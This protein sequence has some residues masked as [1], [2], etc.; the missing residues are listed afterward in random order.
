MESILVRLKEDEKQTLSRFYLYDGLSE[1]FNCVVLELPDRGNKKSISRVNSGKYTCV[2]RYSEKY[3]WH[4]ILLNVEGREY[5]LIH[6]GNYYT[7]TRGCLIFGN[8]FTDINGDGYLD[9]T[10]S[11]KTMKRLLSIAPDK[12]ELTIKEI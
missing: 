8:N 4:Y 6:F 9:V 3:K 7:D 2:L 5:I 12:F 1:V 10:S 11:K